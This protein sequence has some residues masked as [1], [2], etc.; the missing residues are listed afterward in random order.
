MLDPAAARPCPPPPA[1]PTTA[2]TARAV[3]AVAARHEPTPGVAPDAGVYAIQVFN[4]TRRATPTSSTSCWPST[5]CAALADAGMDIVAVNLS[6]ATTNTYAVAC[7]T[8]PGAD[9]DA[10]AFR[11]LF[12]ELLARGHRQRGRVRQLGQPRRASALPACVS[13]ALSVGASDLDDDLADFGNRGPTLDLVAPGVRRGQRR[14]RPHGDPGQPADRSGRARRSPL[15]TWRARSRCSRRSTRRH[16]PSSSAAFMR[17]DGRRPSTSPT[18]G[19]TYRRLRLPAPGPGAGGPGRC[20]R[21]TPAVAGTRRGRRSATSTVTATPT[22]SPTRPGSAPDRISYGDDELEPHRPL[23]RRGRHLRPARRATSA[24]RRGPDDILW[25]AP[26]AAADF[27]WAGGAARTFAS[28]GGHG[29]RHLHRR[30]VGRL[31]R[32]R[33]RRRL[34]VRARARPPT[35]SGTAGRPASPPSPASSSASYR[36]AVGRLRRRRPGR[37][38]VPRPE[39]RRPTALW[40]GTAT[41]GAWTQ[42][43]RS[44]WAAATRSWSAT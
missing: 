16:R 23:V 9:A 3:A 4:P 30:V 36:V 20:S 31:R 28:T 5:T 35:P 6:V 27:V 29:Q 1:I 14:P 38:R 33:L 18:T 43:A 17:V 25:Y 22:C 11:V 42:A 40:R 15:R 41:R 19:A 39:R 32:R 10:R 13:N 12:D 8:G 44:R 21:P 2:T 7:D 26:A 24:G 37:P 34:L